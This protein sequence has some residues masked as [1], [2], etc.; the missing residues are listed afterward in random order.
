MSKL[1]IGFDEE[2]KENRRA[3]RAPQKKPLSKDGR[4]MRAIRPRLF[5]L[6]LVGLA[7]AVMHLAHYV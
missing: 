3:L 1:P 7:W 5:A 2:F 6:G 4:A